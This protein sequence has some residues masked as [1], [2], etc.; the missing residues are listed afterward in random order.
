MGKQPTKARGSP[1][2]LQITATWIRASYSSKHQA[3]MRE[4]VEQ[5]IEIDG[6]RYALVLATGARKHGDFL[7]PPRWEKRWPWR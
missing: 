5:G 6:K 1:A 3:R 2:P 4:L 7:F